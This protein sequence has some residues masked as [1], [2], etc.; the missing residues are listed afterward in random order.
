MIVTKLY[1]NKVYEIN[2]QLWVRSAVVERECN[3]QSLAQG[4]RE[5]ELYYRPVSCNKDSVRQQEPDNKILLTE[6]R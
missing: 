2:K 3:S 6:A 4:L 1:R 5:N